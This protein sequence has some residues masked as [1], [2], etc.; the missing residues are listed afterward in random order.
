MGAGL[1]AGLVLLACVGALLFLKPRPAPPRE[2]PRPVEKPATGLHA[3]SSEQVP[4]DTKEKIAKIEAGLKDGSF[5]IWKGP[6]L[7]QS[8]AV[9]L[10]DGEAA[11]DD[12]LLGINFYVKGVEGSVPS[13]G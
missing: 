12:F 9:K 2:D 6:I 10:K 13:K 5:T 11:T 8:G 4:A 1:V 3:L 7:D